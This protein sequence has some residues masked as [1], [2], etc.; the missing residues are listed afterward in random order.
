MRRRDFD[1]VV[2][3][4]M[5]ASGLYVT[6]TGVIADLFGLHQFVFH[7]YAGYL[8]AG[9]ILV[10]IVL[11]GRRVVGYLRRLSRRPRER[12][13]A[14]EQA[15]GGVEDGARRQ[16][17]I[18]ALSAAGGFLVGWL[19]PD[20]RQELP[21]EAADIGAL[22]H[23]W[24]TPNHSLDLPVPEWG[25]RPPLYKSY[26]EADR[27]ALPGDDDFR[28]LTVEEALSA[29]RSVR[30]YTAEPLPLEVLSR[31]LHAAQGITEERF[32]FRAAP[33]AGALYPIELYP[34]VHSV[35][36]LASGIYH[37]AV[38]EHE[39]ERLQ[40]GDFRSQVTRAG[41]FQSFL[42]QSAVCFLLSAIFQRARWKYRERAYRY[43]LLEAG[44]VGQNLY[45]AATS[46]GLGACAVG[47]FYD[48]QFNRLVGLDPEE[49]AILYVISVGEPV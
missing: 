40:Q 15:A 35:A 32:A 49:E 10:H 44:H 20:G 5:L 21:G 47:A 9:L 38:R 13:A 4:A 12:E 48:D 8:C 16:V 39:L 31:L 2:I 14:A 43:I 11:N 1:Y 28:G 37:Y 3:A 34:V 30:Q 6:V 29:R 45:L 27:I 26:P 23:D 7:S 24:S 17:V 33:S 41:V 36:G 18:A 25:S 46:M 22:Y 19:L 42:G